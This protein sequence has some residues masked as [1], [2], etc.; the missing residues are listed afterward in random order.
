MERVAEVMP[1]DSSDEEVFRYAIKSRAIMVTCNRND[2]LALAS[3]TGN[4]GL[5]IVIRR[6]RA[7]SESG[8]LLELIARA[9]EE[10]II[11]NI[12]FA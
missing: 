7:I 6:R 12:N 8:H 5:I 9:G 11:G 4:H 2:F 1:P 3:L 10:G